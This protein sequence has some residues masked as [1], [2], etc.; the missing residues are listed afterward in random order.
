MAEDRSLAALGLD[1]VPAL[2]PLVYPGRPV[3]GPSLLTGDELLPLDVRPLPLGQWHVAGQPLDEALGE[4][5]VVPVGRRHAV[6]AVGSNASPAQVAY[7]LMRR[8][9]S[10]AVPM[11]PVRVRG[12]AV[13]CSAHIG[14][15]GYVAAAPYLDPVAETSL[16]V[17]WLDQDQFRAVDETEF[18]NYRRALIPGDGF[19]LA[20]P[21]GEKLDGAHLYVSSYGVLVDPDTGL[22]RP[23]GGN[24]AA[25]LA[26]LLGASAA[27]RRLLGPGPADWVRTAAGDRTLRELGTRAFADAGWAL[28][29]P[30]FP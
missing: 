21:S 2:E 26:S 4:R 16:V 11:V 15:A 18:P 8:G 14:R 19:A 7:K 17:S 6:I 24:Q 1:V 20:M 12:I 27:L 10:A 9:I 3:R 28:P 30:G 13:G 22:P 25:L 29:Q 23:G 5:G